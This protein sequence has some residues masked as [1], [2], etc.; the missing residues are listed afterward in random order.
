M[1]AVDA[2]TG[3]HIHDMVGNADHFLVVLHQ[4]DGVAGVTQP[5][6]GAF[7]P[8]D[9]AVV[10]AD[11]RLVQD[12]QDVRERR[13]DVFG[14]FA[15]LGLAPGERSYRTVQAQIPQADFLQGREARTDGRLHVHGQRVLQALNPRI[16]ARDGHGACFGNVPALDFAA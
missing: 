2:G 13:I 9:V 4:Q 8:F 10:E 6:H 14:D 15:A 12:V 7:H 5:L 3:A 16:E 1:A 11:A